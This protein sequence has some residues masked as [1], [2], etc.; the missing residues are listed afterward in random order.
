MKEYLESQLKMTI[1]IEEPQDNYQGLPL[2][3]KT[4]YRIY[5]VSSNGVIWLALEPKNF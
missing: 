2:L 1:T 3:Y 4:Q 5:T